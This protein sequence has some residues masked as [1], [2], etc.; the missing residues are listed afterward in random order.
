VEYNCHVFLDVS[1]SSSSSSSLVLVSVSI[2]V[3]SCSLLGLTFLDCSVEY[4][5]RDYKTSA[6]RG[7]VS[8]A[9]IHIGPNGSAEGRVVAYFNVMDSVAKLRLSSRRLHQE[10]FQRA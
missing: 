1:V 6:L 2:S 10:S 5:H 4:R 7:I 8:T 3:E 9:G